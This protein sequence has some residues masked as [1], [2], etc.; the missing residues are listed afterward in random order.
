VIAEWAV[1]PRGLAFAL[2]LF[3]EVTGLQQL[4]FELSI[5]DLID[6]SVGFQL[7]EIS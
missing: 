2:H 1:R 3:C 6:Y 7:S 5:L 4:R